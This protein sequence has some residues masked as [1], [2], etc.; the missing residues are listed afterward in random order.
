MPE[1]FREYVDPVR[2]KA[3]IDRLEHER[4][5]PP[6]PRPHGA[7]HGVVLGV[8]RGQQHK[9]GPHRLDVTVGGDESTEVVIRVPHGA[10]P[11]WDGKKVVLYLE[12]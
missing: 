8:R 12:D 9:D 2:P 7:V 6:I 4:G 10:C 1:D 3:A 5:G 11:N